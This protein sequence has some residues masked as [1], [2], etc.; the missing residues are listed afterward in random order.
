M[1][2]DYNGRKVL[3]QLLSPQNKRY[4]DPD[5]LSVLHTPYVPDPNDPEKQI[6]TYKKDPE[7]RQMEL[8]K[9]TDY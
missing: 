3:L 4:L 5:E 6:V 8:L 7:V 9:V 2:N 1:A